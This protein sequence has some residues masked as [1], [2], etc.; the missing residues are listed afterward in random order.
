MVLFAGKTDNFRKNL[1]IRD[2]KRVAVLSVFQSMLLLPP[3]TLT[4]RK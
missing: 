2:E 1:N 3:K 4:D